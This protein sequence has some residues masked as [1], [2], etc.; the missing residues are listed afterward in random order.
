MLKYVQLQIDGVPNY[1]RNSQVSNALITT[2]GVRQEIGLFWL[3][4]PILNSIFHNGGT[5]CFN[6]G[7]CINPK[8]K[9]AAVTLSNCYTRLADK[10]IMWVRDL[11][12]L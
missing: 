4:F 6:S 10:V 7:L 2:E 3:V 8:D 5:G 11:S 12:N 9:I 1:I